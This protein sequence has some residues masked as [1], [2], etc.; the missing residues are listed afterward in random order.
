M[1]QR[2]T[3]HARYPTKLRTIAQEL[4]EEVSRIRDARSSVDRRYA[5]SKVCR[6][7][8]HELPLTRDFFH[9]RKPRKNHSGNWDS[10]C[11]KCKRTKREDQ[12]AARAKA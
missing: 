1:N 11:R 4:R 6:D 12:R 8:K 2:P 10:S 9:W 7:C 3:L 5:Y